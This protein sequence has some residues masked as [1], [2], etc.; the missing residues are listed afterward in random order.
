[1]LGYRPNANT[2]FLCYPL[3]FAVCV[4]F[5]FLKLIPQKGISLAIGDHLTV[6]IDAIERYETK[7]APVNIAVVSEWVAFEGDDLST[8]KANEVFFRLGTEFVRKLG[9]VDPDHTHAF[10]RGDDE[11]VTV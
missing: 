6:D 11:R 2:R 4:L 9:S 1:M 3:S 10:T 7:K 5:L 8:N